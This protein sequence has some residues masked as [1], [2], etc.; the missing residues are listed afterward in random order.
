MEKTNLSAVEHSYRKG[1][2]NCFPGIDAVLGLVDELAVYDSLRG[3]LP[4]R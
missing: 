3:A 2:V 4:S 1:Q